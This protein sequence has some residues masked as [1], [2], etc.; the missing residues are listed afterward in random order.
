MTGK[1]ISAVVP[2]SACRG[3]CDS[4]L[5]YT[6]SPVHRESDLSHY[7]SSPRLYMV[8]GVCWGAADVV[9]RHVNTLIAE[10]RLYGNTLYSFSFRVNVVKRK[11]TTN[12]VT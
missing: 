9:L 8:E 11:L 4:R 12:T 6:T 5:E 2:N 10:K 3:Q 1:I 7:P